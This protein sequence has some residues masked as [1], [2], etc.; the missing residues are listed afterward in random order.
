MYVCMYSTVCM[1]M[2]R[3]VCMYVCTVKYCTQNPGSDSV[4]QY[5]YPYEV[6][7]IDHSMYV[8]YV[9]TVCIYSALYVCTDVTV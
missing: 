3:Y 2:Y 8:L 4:V 9:C 1:Y 6:L 7:Q 5:G